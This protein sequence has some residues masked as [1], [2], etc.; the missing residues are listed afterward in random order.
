MY[1]IGPPLALLASRICPFAGCMSSRPLR[2]SGS[3][4]YSFAAG[5]GPAPATATF[6]TRAADGEEWQVHGRRGFYQR[7]KSIWVGTCRSIARRSD[8]VQM[9][10]AYRPG[11]SGFALLILVYLPRQ[12]EILSCLIPS[13]ARAGRTGRR[14]GFP[15]VAWLWLL[16]STIKFAK[17]KFRATTTRGLMIGL[18]C[19]HRGG[20]AYFYTCNVFP[21]TRKR[22]PLHSLGASTAH[23]HVGKR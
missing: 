18:Y 8:L 12:S 21:G 22:S 5:S 20:L 16:G 9:R 17:A 3:S 4:F 10:K 15:A 1:D 7:P 6:K 19:D 11:S 13:V 23:D 2:G 14:W